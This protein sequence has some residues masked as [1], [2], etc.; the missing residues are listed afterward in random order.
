MNTVECGGWKLDLLNDALRTIRWHGVEVVR[1]ID[2]PIRDENWGTYPQ[3][4]VT[5]R[6]NDGGADRKAYCRSFTVGE[7]ALAGTLTAEIDP[8]GSIVVSLALAARR[9]FLTSRAGFVV[10]HPIAGVAGTPL[11]VRHSDGSREQTA[12]P[13]LIAPAQPAF[14]ITGLEHA[15]RGVRVELDFAGEVFEMEDQRNWSDASYKTYCRP[16]ASPKPY[17]IEAGEE[18][19]QTITLRAS[20]EPGGTSA[21]AAG[22]AT[23]GP[24]PELLLAVEAGWVGAAPELEGL[25][26]LLRLNAENLGGEP[27]ILPATQ[28]RAVDLEVV[29]PEGAE[30]GPH[31]TC[32]AAALAGQGVTPR[33]VMALPEAYLKSYQP[34]GDWPTG[35]SPTE[36]A[37]A[38]RSAFPGARIG[39][40]VLTNF[41][42]LNRCRPEPGVGDYLT[43]STTAIVHA[44]DDRSV[45]ETL[46]AL[47]QILES[48]KAVAPGL[49]I[50]LGLVSIGM[51]TNPYGAGV[52]PNPERARK[53]MAQED[54]R[55]ATAFAAE[56]ARA[57][58]AAAAAAGCEAI[59]LSSPAGPFAARGEL[60]QTVRALA[61]AAG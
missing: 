32:V 49:P 31:L 2:C 16:L 41:T 1:G 51:R 18:V 25:P 56:F 55:Q 28:G 26:V 4:D 38:A 59:A 27:W 33:R 8:A 36:A 15:C 30:P 10:L 11:A 22:A 42:E 23:D 3:E 13:A 19:V 35:T 43:F 60:L 5:E 34:D 6:W 54:P 37:R 53:A 57:A 7:G 20:G 48:A 12:F 14:D 44:A 17:R 52:A 47:P 39:V 21:P 9:T 61:D 45:R 46:E 58:Y 40:G 29:I 50:R 24:P